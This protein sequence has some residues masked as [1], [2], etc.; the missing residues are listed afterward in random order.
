MSP[1]TFVPYRAFAKVDAKALCRNF[2]LLRALARRQNPNARPIAVVKDNAYGHGLETV[3]PLLLQAG[4]DFFAVA[5][6]K[7]ALTTRALCPK[8]DILVLGYTP[9]TEVLALAT[10]G[11]TQ[12]VFSAAYAA[13]LS[14]TLSAVGQKLR[15]HVKIDGGLCRGGLDPTD[16]AGLRRVLKQRKLVPTGLYTH[17]PVA[18]TDAEATKRA[19]SGLLTCRKIAREAGFDLFCHSAASAAALTLPESVL[20]GIRVGIALYGLPPVKTDLPLAPVLSLH[21]PLIQLRAVPAGTPVGYGGAL[22]TKRPSLIGTLPV[23]Y[24]DGFCRALSK[25]AVTLWHGEHS[26]S[27]PVAGRICMDHTMVDVTDTPAEVGDTVCLWQDASAPAA[28]LDTI[29]YEVL[30]ALSPRV[31]RRLV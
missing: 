27:V 30:T 3:L 24:G 25:T 23:G 5:T 17:F 6:A 9:P 14:A 21:A 29:P 16:A 10:A 15:I 1:A 20:D 7:E 22:V 8:A 13:A 12:S 26:F 18:D 11:I 19:L 4:C 28:A 31:E 2:D